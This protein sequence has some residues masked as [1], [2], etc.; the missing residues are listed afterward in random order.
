VNWNILFFVIL[1]YVALTVCIVAGIYRAIY[2]PFTISS[3]SS[4]LLERKKLFW[5]SIPFHYGIVL[6]LLGHLFALFLPRQLRLWNSAPIRLYLLEATGLA[7]GLWALA[8]LAVL[9]W[10]RLS[11]RRVRVVTTPM[12]LVLLLL[13]LV[14]V[15]TG[16]LT[17]TVYRF[18][19]SWFTTVFTPYLWSVLTFRP[20]VSLVAPLPW[21][22]K[23]H[24]VNFFV[25]LAV[26]PFS[27]LIHI[28][29]YP[30]GYLVRPWQIVLW[31][32]RADVDKPSSH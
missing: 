3:M 2:R 26:L 8:G 29:V 17:A 21:V 19:S 4:Q 20:L 12:D 22:I 7:L 11:E 9:L 14:S 25:L 10:R 28:A 6:V 13:L 18:G 15:I 32:R 16:V 27:R 5:G 31:N 24:V 1:P 30:I 23:L